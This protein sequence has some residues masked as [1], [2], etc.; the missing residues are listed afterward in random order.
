MQLPDKVIDALEKADPSPWYLYIA[1]KLICISKGWMPPFPDSVLLS[2]KRLS[3]NSA[4]Y[5]TS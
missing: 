1:R 3:H 5:V 2:G 4:M